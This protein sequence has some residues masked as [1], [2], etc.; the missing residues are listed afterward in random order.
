MDHYPFRISQRAMKWRQ[1]RTQR[2]LR[3]GWWRHYLVWSRTEKPTWKSGRDPQWRP[4]TCVSETR[5]LNLVG[6]D[7]GWLFLAWR[8]DQSLLFTDSKIL[9]LENTYIFMFFWSFCFIKTH[10]I[11]NNYATTKA[12]NENLVHSQFIYLLLVNC[13]LFP[14]IYYFDLQKWFINFDGKFLFIYSYCFGYIH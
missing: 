5:T 8:V 12:L 9:K 14:D 11:A 3:K 1:T 10:K 6:C 2:W 7:F 4:V 13:Q